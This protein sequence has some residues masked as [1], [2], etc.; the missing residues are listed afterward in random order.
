MGD[1]EDVLSMR[2]F[3]NCG[4]T[5]SYAARLDQL[6]PPGTAFDQR[7]QR[8]LDDR[9]GALHIL[10]PVLDNEADAYLA[11]GNDEV[12]QRQWARENG[13]AATSSLED[14]LLAQI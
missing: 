11:C 5:P 2:L 14:I 4:L 6:A 10:K 12:M 13:L 9:F 8:F 3:Q 1:G 7:R